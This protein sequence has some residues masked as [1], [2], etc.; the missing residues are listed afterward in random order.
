VTET[1]DVVDLTRAW[2][3]AALAVFG[4]SCLA[5]LVASADRERLLAR[6]GT[7]P[8]VG[9]QRSRRPIPPKV[10]GAVGA[11][12]AWFAGAAIG[13]PA[14]GL[15]VVGTVAGTPVFLR[16]RREARR[17]AALQEQLA[18]GVG[19][20]A[21]GLRSGRSLLG[22]V[23]LA[24]QELASPLGPTFRSVADR[25]SLGVPLEDTLTIW[26]AEVGGPDA[27]VTAGVLGLHRRTGG[28]LATALD[29]L[30]ATLR[31]RRSAA[32]ELRSLTAQARLSATILGLLPIGFFLF[33]SVVARSDVESAFG[34]TLGTG[35]VVLGFTMQGC[36]YL[37]IR[38]LLRIEP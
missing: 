38:R 23:E 16:R 8:T 29:G 33:L 27:R 28:A 34:T 32:R 19:V 35:A 5:I 15:A 26:A 14:L 21:S 18:D 12:P 7:G 25:V 24:G 1:L 36:A 2:A 3:G 37:W 4:V 30:A 6:V 10:L 11:V 13:G 20:I 17:A 22:A 31:A 9:A